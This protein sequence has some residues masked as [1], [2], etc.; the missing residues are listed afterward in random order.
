MPD[1]TLTENTGL[2]QGSAVQFVWR[3]DRSTAEWYTFY[4]V[5]PG[6]NR[7]KIKRWDRKYHGGWNGERLAR[8]TDTQVLKERHPQVYNWLLGVLKDLAS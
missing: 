2:V 5:A 1:K 4:V 8:N 3:E 6:V 7:G